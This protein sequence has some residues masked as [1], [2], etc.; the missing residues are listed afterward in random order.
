MLKSLKQLPNCLKRA[1]TSIFLIVFDGVLCEVCAYT[2][3]VSYSCSTW[4]AIS[5]SVTVYNKILSIQC[6]LTV[7]IEPVQDKSKLFQI[8]EKSIYFISIHCIVRGGVFSNSF[9]PTLFCAFPNPDSGFPR[10]YVVVFFV[11]SMI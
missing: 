5:W 7:Q 4:K 3:T 9:N 10:Q 6:N 11:C 8:S 1:E 2:A